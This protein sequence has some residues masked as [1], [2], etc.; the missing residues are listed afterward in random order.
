MGEPIKSTLTYNGCDTGGQLSAR[1]TF[2]TPG[3]VIRAAD[4]SHNE[5]VTLIADAARVLRVATT[6]RPW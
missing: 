6:G 3:G 2:R 4:L 1:L 5:L